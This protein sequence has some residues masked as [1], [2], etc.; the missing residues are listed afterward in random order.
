[1]SAT[2][3]SGGGTASGE[4]AAATDHGS[5]R[6]PLPP[7]ATL[8]ILGGGQ[9]GR[10]LAMSAARLGFQTLVVDPD[11]HA[12]AAQVAN[13]HLALAFD[14][15][16]A[17][18]AL[19]T[20]EAVTTEFENV[21]ASVLEVLA[22]RTR[23]APSAAALAVAQDRLR[24]KRTIEGLGLAVAP[25][26]A[27]DGADDLT[28][29]REALGDIV[30][31]TRRM[32]YDGKG[33]SVLRA[34]EDGTNA[35]RALGGKDLIAERL[36]PLDA[37]IS[38]IVV[39]D[40]DGTLV[41]FDP[42]RNVHEGGILRSSVVPSGLGDALESEGRA[43]AR[44]LAEGLGYVGAMGVEFFVSAGGL[45]VNEIAPRVHN[46]GHWT[47][48][49]CPIDQF[50]AQ[51]RAVM[52]LPLGDGRRIA[53]AEMGNLLGDERPPEGADV[54][55]HL[56]GKREARAG[57]KMGHWTRVVPWSRAAVGPRKP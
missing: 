34:G 16:E 2:P 31:K 52:G 27:V 36:V 57:R 12:P 49:V 14:A 22:A 30:L 1:M 7:G 13:R 20:C 28:A 5:D 4:G 46:S 35:L 26:R 42:A 45:L 19:A 37:E 55:V 53:D 56:Y 9:L 17:L 38:V 32:G 25:Y 44:T 41:C 51:V 39:R 15:D 33:Q 8:G 48:A 54:R 11:P 21:P 24:E 29:A 43:A 23:V 47:E 50:E 40:R 10:M 6:A 18:G 3:R